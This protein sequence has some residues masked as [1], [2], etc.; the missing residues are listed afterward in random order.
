MMV[1]RYFK[2]NLID[3]VPKLFPHSIPT[4]PCDMDGY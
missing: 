1:E 2:H 3:A 4:T